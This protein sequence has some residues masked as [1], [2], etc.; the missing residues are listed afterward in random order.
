M[1]KILL[2]LI[3]S[4]LLAVETTGTV[5]IIKKDGQTFFNKNGREFSITKSRHQARLFA[6]TKKEYQEVDHPM[7]LFSLVAINSL[8]NNSLSIVKAKDPANVKV[9]IIDTGLDLNNE[10]LKDYCLVNT[11]EIPGNGIDD[12]NN[13]Y[14]DD[15]FGVNVINSNGSVHD[16]HSHGTYMASVIAAKSNGNVKIIPIKAFNSAG[17]SSQFLIAEAIVCAVNRGADI[18]NCSFGYSYFN[19]TFQ[20]AVQYALDNGVIVIAAAGNNGS[21][22]VMYPAGFDGV[23]SVSSLDDNDRLSYFS[24]YGDHI[25]MSCLGERIPCIGVNG[26]QMQVS[27]TS[28]SSAFI[29][30]VL[31]N[32]NG[33]RNMELNEIINLY[34]KDVMYPLGNVKPYPG[35]DKYTGQGKIMSIVFNDNEQLAGQPLQSLTN[36][37]VGEF[38][39]YPNPVKT[40]GTTQFGFDVNKGATIELKVYSLNGKELWKCEQNAT[41]GYNK[42]TFEVA[43]QHGESLGNDSYIAI[44]KVNDG[45]EEVTRKTIVTVLR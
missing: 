41:I 32:L 43:N 27:G 33:L 39:N 16:D 17:I 22:L 26:A 35:W 10:E 4:V 30:G 23:M 7:E 8:P 44:L 9:A 6:T 37:E 34:S 40:G 24:N 31:A 14:I 18:I 12:D 15:Y 11:N 21:E 42:I 28:V 13:G 2:F 45:V 19:E 3:L 38:L 1:R 5:K 25:K 20:S 36:L 29:S